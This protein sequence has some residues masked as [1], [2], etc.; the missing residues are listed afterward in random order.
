MTIPRTEPARNVLGEP[1]VP[2]SFDPLTGYFR[3]GCC[4]TNDE[5]V[6]THVI[7]AVMT[8]EFLAFSKA[9]GN[10][11][12]TPQPQWRFPGLKPGDQWCLCALRWKEA[13]AAGAAPLVVL[14]STHSKALQ[15]VTFDELERFAYL[16]TDVA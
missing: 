11:L 1:L 12:S 14:E 5:D 7:C 2:C 3:D 13:F 15:I 8:A 16:G 6:G 9:R 4:K 10:D